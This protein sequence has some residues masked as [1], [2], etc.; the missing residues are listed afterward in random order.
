MAY[1]ALFLGTTDNDDTGE[2]P[3][4]AGTKINSNFVELYASNTLI[5]AN[6]KT[7]SYTLVLADAGTIIEMN[8]SVANTVTVPPNSV[9]AFPINTVIEVIQ[10]GTGLTTIAAGAGV[11]LR[12]PGTLDIR[13]RWASLSLRKRATDEWV[14]A[15]DSA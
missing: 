10:V 12:A 2:T 13:V 14:V 15:G 3:K 7:S 4:A 8:L 11:T 1:Q 6:T 9:V 5:P